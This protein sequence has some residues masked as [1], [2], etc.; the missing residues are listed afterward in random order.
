MSTGSTVSWGQ[1]RR[2]VTIGRAEWTPYLRASYEAVVTTP[3][4]PSWATTTGL[5]RSSGCRSISIDT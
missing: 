3:R 2:A 5:P 4:G 1:R